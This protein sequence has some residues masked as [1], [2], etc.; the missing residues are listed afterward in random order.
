VSATWSERPPTK[1]SFDRA[2]PTSGADLA[3]GAIAWKWPNDNANC[4]T[5]AK[6][7]MQEAH[8][9]FDRTHVTPQRPQA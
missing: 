3:A 7:A 2:K 5:S 1:E 8:L 9:M 4:I 6:S